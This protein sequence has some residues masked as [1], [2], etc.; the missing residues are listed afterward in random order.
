MAGDHLGA[1]GD[2]HLVDVA[3][4]QHLAV[5][6]GRR[7]RVVVA[8][9]AHQRQRADPGAAP[10]AGLVGDR[11]QRQQRGEVARQPLADASRRG[12]AGER[13]GA[14]G[15]A[16]RAAAFS[17][18]KLVDQ[19]HR[20]QEVAPGVADQPLDLAFVV[21]LAR[22]AEAVGEQVVRLQLGEDPRALARAVA[23][24]CAPPP[25]ACCRRGSLAAR[26]RR[27][28]TPRCARRRTPPSSRPDRPS[29]S[30]RPSAAGRGRR[31]G[32]SAPRRRSPPSPRRSRPARARAD[33]PAART[34]PAPAAAAPHVVLHD[35]LAAG[36]AV[37]V[38]QPLEDPLRR[39]PL[40]PRALPGPPPG[41]GR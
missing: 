1:A 10:L 8:P 32:S 2:H 18:A 20:H 38:P 13:P 33:A 17:A 34:S 4:H 30:R 9:V 14:P 21:A 3:A 19:R 39:V 28:R 15:S 24:G 36:E 7:H 41:S 5:A 37:L 22:A 40:L 26:R 29:R 11:G 16:P 27:R 25:A 35:R 6:V 12:R 23:R 31:S